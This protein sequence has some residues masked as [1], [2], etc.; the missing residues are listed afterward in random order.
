MVDTFARRH[1]KF[2][3]AHYHHVI[4]KIKKCTWS[5]IIHHVT[6]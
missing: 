2:I 5:L 4:L 3:I 1:C 6:I